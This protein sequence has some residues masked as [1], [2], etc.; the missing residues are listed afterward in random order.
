LPD[1][2]RAS[3][4]SFEFEPELQCGSYIFMDADY[5][6]NRDRGRGPLTTFKPSIFARYGAGEADE[7]EEAFQGNRRPAFKLPD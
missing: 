6:R 3:T 7:L 2:H 4:G 5:G 1:R